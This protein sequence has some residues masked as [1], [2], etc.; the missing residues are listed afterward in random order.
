MD[1]NQTNINVDRAAEAGRKLTDPAGSGSE[2]SSTAPSG[3]TGP[4]AYEQRQVPTTTT[5]ST[6]QKVYREGESQGEY[7]VSGERIS[8]IVDKTLAGEAPGS[9]RTE[10]ARQAIDQF[11]GLDVDTKLAILYYLYAEMGKS[12]TPA[13]PEAANASRIQSFFSQFDG[14]SSGDVQLEAMRAL[15]RCDDSQLSRDYGNYTENDKL[16][17]WFL[18]AERMGKDV[19]DVPQDYQLIDAGKQNLEAIKGL[20]FEQQITFLRD[21]TY[22]MGKEARVRSSVVPCRFGHL[23]EPA[24][25]LHRQTLRLVKVEQVADLNRQLPGK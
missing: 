7:N 23:F 8:E 24:R 2:Q 19:I 10:G 25:P 20:D 14:L 3:A 4:V 5:G 9:V 16:Y 17:T 21:V 18:L 15:V 13:A 22:S 6:S 12:V 11:K 1:E